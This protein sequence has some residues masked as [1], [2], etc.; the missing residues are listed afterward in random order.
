MLWVSMTKKAK[1]LS[2]HLG[3]YKP[4]ITSVLSIMHRISGVALFFGLILLLWWFVSLAYGQDPEA[5]LAW[6][7][8]MSPY[9]RVL[10]MLWSYSLFFHACT[11]VRHLLW[12]AGIGFSMRAVDYGG[13][14]AVIISVILTA[15]AWIAAL[16]FQVTGG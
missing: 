13:W 6:R 14:A 10:V 11:G 3:I 15:I 12:D 1:P 9:G 2:P 8:L 16:Q 4:Q 7:V 5:T